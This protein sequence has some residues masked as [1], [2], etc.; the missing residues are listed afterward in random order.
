MDD[1]IRYEKG[2]NLCDYCGNWRRV[3]IQ[4]LNG[5]NVDTYC[6]HCKPEVKDDSRSV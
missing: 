4:Y 3:T 1:D 2:Y 5:T 6:K